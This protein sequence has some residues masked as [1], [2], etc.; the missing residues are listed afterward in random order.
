MTNDGPEAWRIAY[1]GNVAAHQFLTA[2]LLPLLDKGAKAA[3]GHTSVVVNVASVAGLTKTH[4]QGQFA[5]SS[6]KAALLHLTREWAHAFMGL[7]I[8]VNCIAPG[9]FPSEMSTGWSDENQ[10]SWL[11]D[12]GK[13]FPAG[14]LFFLQGLVWVYSFADGVAGRVG[15][16]SDIGS[17]V[18]Y[19]CSR[20][21]TYVN[22][23]VIHV[24]GGE[25]ISFCGLSVC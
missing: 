3:P 8:R 9:L 15:R 18:L 12:A 13:K 4:S 5:Y 6:S 1:A 17:V 14:E 16:E 11:G 10:K 22:G 7:S 21:G 25:D 2:A 23:Q 24:D 20:A 19:L